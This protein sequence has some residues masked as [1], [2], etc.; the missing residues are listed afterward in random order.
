[1]EPVA[2]RKERLSARCLLTR[3]NAVSIKLREL[4]SEQTRRIAS[5]RHFIA[6][7]PKPLA[8]LRRVPQ[9][10]NSS[11][12]CR[13]ILRWTEDGSLAFRRSFRDSAHSK[14]YNWCSTSHRFHQRKAI[15]FHQ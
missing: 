13:A 6:K 4:V 8:E 2:S 11:D 10:G 15:G 1:M 14:R 7:I 12:Q 3:R 9:L 5:M